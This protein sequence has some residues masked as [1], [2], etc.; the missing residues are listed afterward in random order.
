MN[1][2]RLELR[3]LLKGAVIWTL[4]LGGAILLLLAFF[5]SM[6]TEAM[7]SLASAK[8]E[9]I[10]PII[11]AAMGLANIPDFTVISVFFGYVLQFITLAFMVYVSLQATT[12]LTKEETE[13][14]IEFLYAK[15]IS[16]SALFLAKGAALAATVLAML[17]A[18]SALTVCGYLMFSDYTLLA[19]V[20]ECVLFYGA[21][22]FVSLIY[23]A[24]GLLVT[25][26]S[27]TSRSGAGI[28][29]ALVMGTYMLGILSLVIGPLDFLVYFAPMEWIKAEKLLHTGIK[30]IEYAIGIAIIL[31]LPTLSLAIYERK[32]LLV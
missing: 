32:D 18:L 24:V 14:T 5:P 21:I 15:P 17:I 31:L 13:G 9:S 16:R 30:P 7:R 1:V 23:M 11:L 10:A 4:S 29:I 6:Q 26:A 3:N 22:L 28:T 19:A 8:L 12:L 2:F 25:A 20:N 27:H